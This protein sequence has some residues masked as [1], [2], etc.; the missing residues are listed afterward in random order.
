MVKNWK[1]AKTSSQA[2]LIR[3]NEYRSEEYS[4]ELAHLKKRKKLKTYCTTSYFQTILA[5]R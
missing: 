2:A 3:L 1:G 5:F 4:H